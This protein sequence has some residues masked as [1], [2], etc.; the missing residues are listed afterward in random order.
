MFMR[1]IFHVDVNNAFLS[2]TACYLLNHGYEEDIRTIASAIGG[3]EEKRHGIILAKSPVAKKYGVVTAEPLYMARKKCPGIKIF[4]P[5]YEYYILMSKNF[6]NYLSTYTPVIEQASIDECY[7]DLTGTNYLYDDILKLAYKIKNEIKEKFGFTVNVGVANNKL[8]AKMASD[9]EKPDKVHT[10]FDYE[11][12]DK[13]WPL[14]INDLLFVGKSSA[15]LLKSIGIN[16]IGDLAK[17]DLNILKKHFK[18]MAPDLINR[19]NGIDD[20]KVVNDYGFNKCIS[21]SRTLEKDTSDIRKLKKILLDM[22][23]QVGLR[24]RRYKLFAKTITITFKT[25]S[26]KSYSHSMTLTNS[27]N[28]TLDIYNNILVLFDK[29]S[30]EE[31]F[32]SIGIRLGELNTKNMEQVSF[33]NNKDD[34]NIQKLLDNINEKYKNTV[35]MP[36]IFYEKDK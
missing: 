2:W 10:L 29:I 16:T 1:I 13:M 4:P 11:I 3:D 12:K 26:F 31:K 20:S 36:A 34:D 22:S 15:S 24:A 8:C 25:S 33:F 7:L 28:N 18:N 9:F 30:K 23:N 6:Y 17:S 19:A 32:R 27:I 14:P 21:I 35:V 5:N